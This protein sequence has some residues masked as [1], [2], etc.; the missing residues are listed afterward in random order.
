MRHSDYDTVASNDISDQEYLAAMMTEE[1]ET[2]SK[3]EDEMFGMMDEENEQEAQREEETWAQIEMANERERR[4]DIKAWVEI[5]ER[6]K[7]VPGQL[8]INF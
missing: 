6:R 7:E 4:L 2:L 8:K 5:T 1:T 3:W